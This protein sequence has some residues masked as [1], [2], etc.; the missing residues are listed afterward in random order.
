MIHSSSQSL[1][2]K[3]RRVRTSIQHNNA[4]TSPSLDW[5]DIRCA[6]QMYT[7]ADVWSRPHRKCSSGAS[8]SKWHAWFASRCLG[9]HFSTWPTTAVSCLTALGALWSQLTFLLAWCHEHS[10]LM[11]PRD[12][13]YGTLFQSSCII[14]TSPMD[15]SDE[16]WRDTFFGK[17]KNGALWFLICST[18]ENYLLTYLHWSSQSPPVKLRQVRT[19]NYKQSSPCHDRGST[20]VWGYT[21]V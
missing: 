1:P 2:V 6:G 17:H 14:L 3:L 9:R 10:E 7:G 15:C 13:A 4:M 12:L 21:A 18:I 11:Q 5:G 19:S 8:S 16:S 20:G